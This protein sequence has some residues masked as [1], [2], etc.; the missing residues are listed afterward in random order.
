MQGGY[1]GSQESE[2]IPDLRLATAV[3]ERN[4]RFLDL[5]E[6][7][8]HINAFNEG[9]RGEDQDKD[10]ESLRSHVR[11]IE[12]QVAVKDHPKLRYTTYDGRNVIDGPVKHSVISWMKNPYGKS[13]GFEV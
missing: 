7:H 1:E 9:T 10:Q 2:H 13:K 3:V 8:S 11:F 5:V 4:P 6:S 12:D